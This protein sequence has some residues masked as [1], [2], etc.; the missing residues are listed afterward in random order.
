MGCLI[1]WVQG[2]AFGLGLGVANGHFGG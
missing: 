2:V 1:E